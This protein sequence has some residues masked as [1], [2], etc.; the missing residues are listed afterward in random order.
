M[1]ANLHYSEFLGQVLSIRRPIEG[2]LLQVPI[3]LFSPN[4]P[5]ATITFTQPMTPL[6]QVYQAVR[7][8][9]ADERIAMAKAGVAV[10]KNTS[11]IEVEEN[12]SGF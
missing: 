1:F 10:A 6:F 7:I 2:S 11:D 9:R 3:P 5:I 12:I 8:A 4:Q